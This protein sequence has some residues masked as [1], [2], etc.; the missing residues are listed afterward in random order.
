M[1]LPSNPARCAGADE[2]PM[3]I[4]PV[5]RG[6]GATGDIE[7]FDHQRAVEFR[8]VSRARH[9]EACLEGSGGFTIGGK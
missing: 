8:R 3:Q 2:F 7:P 5:R 6:I 9:D 4:R 1:A